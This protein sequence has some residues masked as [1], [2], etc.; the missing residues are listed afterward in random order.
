MNDGKLV[1][2]FDALKQ[3]SDSERHLAGLTR[4]LNSY[5]FIEV[6]G[7]SGLNPGSAGIVGIGSALSH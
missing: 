7:K 1:V 4:L 6:S 5:P 3:V 2:R